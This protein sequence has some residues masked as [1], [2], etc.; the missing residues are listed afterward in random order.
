MST[1]LNF[2]NR[3]TYYCFEEVHNCILVFSGFHRLTASV[4]RFGHFFSLWTQVWSHTLWLRQW[5]GL[6]CLLYTITKN[7]VFEN[8]VRAASLI[9]QAVSVLIAALRWECTIPTMPLPTQGIVNNQ[10]FINV[11][12]PPLTHWYSTMCES[13]APKN[14]RTLKYLAMFGWF[15]YSTN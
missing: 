15:W 8:H 10:P 9:M 2:L 5:F 11:Y 14:V 7:I 13:V 3:V 1:T 4:V 12:V 6:S